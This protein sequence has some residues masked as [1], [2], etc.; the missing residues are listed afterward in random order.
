MAP[1]QGSASF[2]GKAGPLIL[3]RFCTALLTVV[4]PLVLARGLSLPDY[5]TYKQLFLIFSTLFFIVPFGMVQGIYFFLPRS[6]VRRPYVTHVLMYLAVVGVAAAAAIVLGSGEVA[7]LF[8][9]PALVR[10]RWPLAIYTGALVGAAPLEISLTAQ[11]KTKQSAICYLISDSTRALALTVP[12][13][14]GRGL[15]GA[16]DASALYAVLRWGVALAVL[17]PGTKGPWFSRAQLKAQVHWALPFGFAMA[18]AIPQQWMH[19]Y[20]VSALVTP[21]MFA[22]YAVGCFQLPIVNLLYTPTSEVLMVRIGELEKANRLAEGLEAFREAVGKLSL[23][24]LPCAAFL[25]AASPEFIGAMFG[26]KYLPA[27]PIFRVSV[28]GIVLAIFPLDGALRARNCTR[29]ILFSYAVKMA[30][31]VPLVLWLVHRMGMIGGII[32]WAVAECVGK[33]VLAVRVPWAL[34]APGE[35]I[36]ARRLVPWR[37]LFR[38]ACAAALAAGGVWVARALTSGVWRTLPA[39]FLARLL[40]L[41]FV[42]LLFGGFYL[43]ALRALGVRPMAVI[44]SLR[45]P[46]ARVG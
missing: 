24:F 17:I 27:V 16:M 12:V 25:W 36:R 42:G 34:S 1:R 46:K 2:L 11:N 32:S 5:G 37:E 43:V 9:N 29:H 20:V 26:A 10:F 38:A 7:R 40:P 33:A 31:T 14:L 41:T 30:V 15:T 8:H 6:D 22:L 23:V 35:R 21:K 28:V 44:A 13:L 3:A 18:I 39:S 19:Q 4:I 45:S